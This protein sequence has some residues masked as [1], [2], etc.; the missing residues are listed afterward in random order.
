MHPP[1][2]RL[3]SVPFSK[4]SCYEWTHAT[5]A[6]IRPCFLRY[7]RHQGKRAPRACPR[8]AFEIRAKCNNHGVFACVPAYHFQVAAISFFSHLR[9]AITDGCMG[10]NMPFAVRFVFPCKGILNRGSYKPLSCPTRYL[11]GS[12]M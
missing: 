2:W 5:K 8:R 7:R 10:A 12:W 4:I 11:I 3:R 9:H 1:P 6:K